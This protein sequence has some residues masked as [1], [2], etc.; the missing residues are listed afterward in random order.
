MVGATH[1]SRKHQ[2][3]WANEREDEACARNTYTLIVNFTV[4][5]KDAGIFPRNGLFLQAMELQ[6][7][8]AQR[9]KLFFLNLILDFGRKKMCCCKEAPVNIE[10]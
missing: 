2:L 10:K 3:V 5:D 4:Q 1:R 9:R 6:L 7:F 8:A